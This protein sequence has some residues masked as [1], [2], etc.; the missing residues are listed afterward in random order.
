[1]STIHYFNRLIILIYSKLD[2]QFF[3]EAWQTVDALAMPIPRR[4]VCGMS[5]LPMPACRTTTISHFAVM[6]SHKLAASRR[7]NAVVTDYDAIG[8][9]TSLMRYYGGVP[10]RPHSAE[11]TVEK[12]TK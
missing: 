7:C 5:M 12:S 2:N 1:M 6:N 11:G 3:F 10:K 4:T 9:G 8:T